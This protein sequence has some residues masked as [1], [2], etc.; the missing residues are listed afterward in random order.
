MTCE[1][2]QRPDSAVYTSRIKMRLCKRKNIQINNIVTSD[3]HLQLTS[4][5][6]KNFISIYNDLIHNLQNRNRRRVWSYS[7]MIVINLYKDY[8]YRLQ[9]VFFSVSRYYSLPVWNTVNFWL[10]ECV[11]SRE[12]TYLCDVIVYGGLPNDASKLRI[13]Q[14]LSFLAGKD[15][16]EFAYSCDVLYLRILPVLFLRCL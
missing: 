12:N 9:I 13:A 1:K 15:V 11:G 6:N 14:N 2:S 8:Y 5:M 10:V 16:A 3:N 7:V 4:Q